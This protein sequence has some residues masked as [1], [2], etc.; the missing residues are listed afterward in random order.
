M[1]LTVSPVV[2]FVRWIPAEVTFLRS[3]PFPLPKRSFIRLQSVSLHT[4]LTLSL[5]YLLPS[6]TAFF[7]FAKTILTAKNRGYK[8]GS[9]SCL[10][11]I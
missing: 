5:P 1:R 8:E 11:Q 9:L 4:L 10:L 7:D 2:W 3:F 6:P